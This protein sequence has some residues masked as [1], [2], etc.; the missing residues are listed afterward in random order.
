MSNNCLVT[1]YKGSVNIENP[2]KFGYTKIHI[3]PH[4]NPSGNVASKITLV[5]DEA[6]DLF[7]D[8]ITENCHFTT[9]DGS[10]NLGTKKTNFITGS[11]Y[12]SDGSCDLYIPKYNHLTEIEL[13]STANK[14]AVIDFDNFVYST[15]LVYLS[16]YPA[17]YGSSYAKDVSGELSSSMLK[18]TI[19]TI[20]LGDSGN[21][22]GNLTD[23]VKTKSSLEIVDVWKSQ[24]EFDM[25]ILENYGQQIKYLGLPNNLTNADIKYFGYTNSNVGGV[26][27]IAFE[28]VTGTL[29]NLASI[30][31]EKIQDSGDIYIRAYNSFTN[32]TYNDTPIN[33]MSID[34]N[35]TV[36]K[37]SF[38]SS[39]IIT[40][41]LR[42]SSMPSVS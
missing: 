32:V 17:V 37:V 11:I 16:L 5:F 33:E 22:R 13:L 38:N 42:V 27:A 31:A 12:I 18:D 30:R 29:E 23:I 20:R 24:M 34:G 10:N 4:P 1:K 35:G 15:K 39:G 8:N 7:M 25:S 41:L 26:G 9:S 40:G 28:L 21:L 6:V 2:E 36:L 19:K 3:D 14:R